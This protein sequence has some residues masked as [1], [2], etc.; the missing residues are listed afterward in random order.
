MLQT[1][2][3]LLQELLIIVAGIGGGLFGVISDSFIELLPLFGLQLGIWYLQNINVPFELWQVLLN[4]PLC[5]VEPQLV[6]LRWDGIIIQ[7]WFGQ[8]GQYSFNMRL[9]GIYQLLQLIGRWLSWGLHYFCSSFAFDGVLFIT[10]F[11]Y[12]FLL[13]DSAL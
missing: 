1:S 4:I 3:F 2:D 13:F 11:I 5:D 12:L 6:V 8:Y 10:V 7:T 9:H